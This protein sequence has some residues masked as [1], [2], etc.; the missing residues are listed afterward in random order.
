MQD[1]VV[2]ELG[3]SDLGDR[4][5]DKRL[6]RL[7]DKASQKPTLSIPAGCEGWNETIAAYRFFD[8]GKVTFEKVLEPHITSTLERIQSQEVVLA[9]Q[10]TTELDLTRP[11]RRVEDAG[12]MNC[13][14]RWGFFLHPM[15]AATPEGVPLGIAGAEIWARDPEEFARNQRDKKAREK[16]RKQVSI[17]NKESHRWLKGYL[18]ACEIQARSPG[19]Q[20]VSVSDS[21]SDIFE[22][23]AA[24]ARED[25]PQKADFIVR[26]CQNRALAGGDPGEKSKLMDE[27]ALSKILGKVELEVSKNESK[28]HDGRK[29]KQPRSARRTTASVQAKRLRLRAPHRK[30]EKLPDVE[31]NVVLVREIDP[32]K[33]EPPVEWVLLTSLPIGSMEEVCRVIEYYCVRWQIEIYFRVLKSGCK[34]EDRQLETAD[35]YKPCL[36]LYMIVAWRVMYMMMLGRKCPEMPCDS[37]LSEDEWK[38]VYRIVK[39]EEPPRE[40]PN[41]QKMVYM[42]ASLG[43]HLGRKSD[44]PPGPKTMWIGMQRMMD[45][46]RAWRAFRVQA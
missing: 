32:P 17:E 12:P 38:A 7:V 37:V 5:L 36:A 6:V 2:E 39:G 4:R 46:A 11:N 30:G 42:I 22:C 26:G 33:D 24:S 19:V 18:H 14:A 13:D 16:K 20:I 3:T 15:L 45:F 9:L 34:A 27:L 21:E 43:G 29:R 44:G 28:T 23:F 10:D 40:P 31:M 1:W 35:R 8:N 41:L 25:V